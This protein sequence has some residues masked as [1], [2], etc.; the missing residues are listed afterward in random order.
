MHGPCVTRWIQ[1]M[2]NL[3]WT[4]AGFIWVCPNW[5][6]SSPCERPGTSWL[7]VWCAAGLQTIVLVSVPRPT[8]LN[9]SRSRV[10]LK[11]YQILSWGFALM[12]WQPECFLEHTKT[13]SLFGSASMTTTWLLHTSTKLGKK[14][15]EHDVPTGVRTRINKKGEAVY[16]IKKADK[17]Q[18]FKTLVE[19][20]EVLNQQWFAAFVRWS[21]D[22][23]SYIGLTYSLRWL[24]HGHLSIWGIWCKQ[25]TCMFDQCF[26]YQR[27]LFVQ[28]S[29]TTP[30]IINIEFVCYSCLAGLQ[31][32]S[33]YKS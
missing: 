30:N 22:D 5:V 21:D 33:L 2:A 16:Q 6:V 18:S 17:M 19:A 15:K 20:V 31:L 13:A 3:R 27:F 1:Q 7:I 10:R 8:T 29:P 4:S 32:D 12:L 25:Y 24:W 11:T 14:E 9:A 23:L 28:S 26:H